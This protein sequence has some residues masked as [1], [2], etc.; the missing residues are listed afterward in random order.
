[1]YTGNLK[2]ISFIDVACTLGVHTIDFLSFAKL[3]KTKCESFKLVRSWEESFAID[4]MHCYHYLD[5]WFWT[6]RITLDLKVSLN[7]STRENYE[8]LAVC[9]LE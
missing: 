9:C 7:G 2:N 4:M 1:M 3:L 8:L 5:H 6:P